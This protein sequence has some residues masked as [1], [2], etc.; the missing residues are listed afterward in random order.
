M[1]SKPCDE[2]HS[3]DKIDLNNT[4]PPHQA[5]S[6][7]LQSGGHQ[8]PPGTKDMP[9]EEDAIHFASLLATSTRGPTFC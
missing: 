5:M 4:L 6:K 7:I 9:C 1:L 8:A 3:Y 2:K